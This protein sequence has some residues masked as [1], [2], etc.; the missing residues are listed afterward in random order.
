[1]FNED[2]KQ[3]IREIENALQSSDPVQ[4]IENWCWITKIVVTLDVII[5]VY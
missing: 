5:S 1:M 2:R 4:S 3:T